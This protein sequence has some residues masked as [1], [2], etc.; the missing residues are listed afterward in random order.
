MSRGWERILRGKVGL[1]F[2]EGG[3]VEKMC[4]ER[5]CFGKD[6]EDGVGVD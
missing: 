6:G 4:C 2:G 3:K 5:G 1:G